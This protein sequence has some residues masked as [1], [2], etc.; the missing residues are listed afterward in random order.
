[1]KKCKAD[2]PHLRAQVATELAI[3][4][5]ILIFILGG[6]LRAGMGA[7]YVQNQHLKAMRMALTASY[8]ASEAH[9]TGR[10]SAS[11][12]VVEDRLTVGLGGQF[13][14]IDRMPLIYQGSGSQTKNF[15]YPWTWDETAYANKYADLRNRL[16]RANNPQ[17]PDEARVKIE[18]QLDQMQATQDN[19]KETGKEIHLPRFDLIVN[20]Q[21]FEF[22]L[23]GF[24]E[25]DGLNI[26]PDNPT[27]IW[28]DACAKVGLYC[29]IGSATYPAIPDAWINDNHPDWP[30]GVTSVDQD[31]N[32]SKVKLTKG[33]YRVTLGCFRCDKDLTPFVN[34]PTDAF[35]VETGEPANLCALLPSI[36]C[37]LFYK[38]V[39]NYEGSSFCGAEEPANDVAVAQCKPYDKKDEDNPDNLKNAPGCH[40]RDYDKYPE[41]KCR[42][43]LSANERFDLN[44]DGILDD[45]P[46][47]PPGFRQVFSWQWDLVLGIKST[48]KDEKQGRV[49]PLKGEPIDDTDE[50]L[51]NTQVDVDGD[52]K[53]EII[54]E[55]LADD[56]SV[57]HTVRYIDYQQ[58]DV[59][60]TKS[61]HDLAPIAGFLDETQFYGRTQEGTYQQLTESGA[62]VDYVGAHTYMQTRKKNRVDI[63]ER[64]FQLTNDTGRI[65]KDGRPQQASVEACGNCMDAANR[66]LTCFEPG[67]LRLYIRSRI[68]DLSGRRWET[69]VTC[70]CPNAPGP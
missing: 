68:E 42:Q 59:D 57:I 67:E 11:I 40:N 54:K 22:T 43:A 10:N 7:S 37:R 56:N 20:N 33:Q 60:F 36:G 47:D 29:A 18:A 46:D 58:G 44:R 8:L 1:M 39:G 14:T 53:E 69:P 25:I 19:I 38:Q 30:Q 41:V 50:R 51:I 4:G 70:N 27:G 13:A 5:A 62:V 28:D 6:I 26:K 48:K 45:V 21:H 2:C 52:F 12:L 9:A 65:C 35:E 15:F 66:S 3:F 16:A 31:G 24:D 61:D 17:V 23:A 63:I 32:S 55:V 49:H 64:V 34:V